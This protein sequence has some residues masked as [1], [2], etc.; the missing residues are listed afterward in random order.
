MYW[1]QQVM[2]YNLDSIHSIPNEYTIV[3]QIKKKQDICT[4]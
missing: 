1:T 3:L 2:T 4:F